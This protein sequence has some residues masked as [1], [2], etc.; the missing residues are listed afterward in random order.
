MFAPTA[1][2]F[3]NYSVSRVSNITRTLETV[4]LNYL[5]LIAFKYF[6]CSWLQIATYLFSPV[7]GNYALL[8]VLLTI[9]MLIDWLID[10]I[11]FVWR[12]LTVYHFYAITLNKKYCRDGI[13]NIKRK[14]QN[15]AH[16]WAHDEKNLF[17]KITSSRSIN[18]YER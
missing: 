17:K 6:K 11:S 3:Y 13:L 12:N 5:I 18:N 7:N 10:V 15:L 8:P 1:S 9:K 4:F 14:S 2:I 16:N